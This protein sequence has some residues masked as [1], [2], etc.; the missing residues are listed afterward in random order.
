MCGSYLHGYT[1]SLTGAF[2]TFTV[3]LVTVTHRKQVHFDWLGSNSKVQGEGRGR[4]DVG[5]LAQPP[6]DA[7]PEST[8]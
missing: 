1:N 8:F 2:A 6:G 4:G 3:S 7:D 5:L